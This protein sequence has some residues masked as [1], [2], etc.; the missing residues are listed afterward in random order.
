MPLSASSTCCSTSSNLSDKNTS[1][2]G[3]APAAVTV[4][5]FPS[6][7]TRSWLEVRKVSQ[8]VSEQFFLDLEQVLR[9]FPPGFGDQ[10]EVV[11]YALEHGE[12]PDIVQQARRVSR[13]GKFCARPARGG[14]ES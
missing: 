14:D 9:S 4:A 11:G 1:I 5:A 10:V 8:C 3:S 12:A 2:C 6:D 13:F 7:S